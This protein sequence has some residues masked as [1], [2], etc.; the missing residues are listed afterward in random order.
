MYDTQ[1]VFSTGALGW[2]LT[3]DEVSNEFTKYKSMVF[4]LCGCA[5]RCITLG[6]CSPLPKGDLTASVL[7]GG[8]LGQGEQQSRDSTRGT[9][10]KMV[11]CRPAVN[12]DWQWS[13]VAEIIPCSTKAAC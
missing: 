1:C 13:S 2:R 8:C 6:V 4:P 3:A 5:H 12:I 10:R 9:I 11:K 7:A